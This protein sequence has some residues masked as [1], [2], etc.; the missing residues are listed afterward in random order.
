MNAGM[1]HSD[2]AMRDHGDDSI[3]GDIRPDVDDLMDLPQPEPQ[4]DQEPDQ[5]DASLADPKT[6]SPKAVKYEKKARSVFRFAFWTT[7]QHPKTQPDA[8]TI[9]MHGPKVA[10]AFGD[11]A[12]QNPAIARA[13]DMMDETTDNATLAMLMV[14]VPFV[15][16][17]LRNHE[18]EVAEVE[19]RSV[20]IPFTKRSIRIR[21]KVR[22]KRLRAMT[23]EPKELTSY[24]FSNPAIVE[25]LRK[26]GVGVRVR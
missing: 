20:R 8:A 1:P 3:F 14:A 17:L 6:R 19:P 13:I 4:V 26:Q 9:L 12:A 23:N 5:P 21:F 24:V 16:Q 7:V 25:K 18:S 2:N 11:L 22:L 15:A 10:E